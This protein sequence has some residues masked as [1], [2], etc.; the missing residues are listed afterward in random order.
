MQISTD[1][2]E[3]NPQVQVVYRGNPTPSDLQQATTVIAL[4]AIMGL[5]LMATLYGI[6]EEKPALYATGTAVAFSSAVILDYL[7]PRPTIQTVIQSNRQTSTFRT[8]L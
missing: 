2:Y 5:G 3:T 8:F 6:A 1:Q 7:M 4:S